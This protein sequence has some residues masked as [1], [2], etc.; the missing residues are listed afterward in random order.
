MSWYAKVENN[1]VTNVIYVVDGKDSDWCHREY[2]GTWLAVSEDGGIRVVFPGVGYIYDVKRDVFYPPS[3]YASWVFN[4]V[5]WSWIAPI[6]YPEDGKN[7]VW[8]EQTTS[9]VEVGA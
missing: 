7:Y 6:P 3:P 4:E 8:D 5:T 9:W 1:L 2:G